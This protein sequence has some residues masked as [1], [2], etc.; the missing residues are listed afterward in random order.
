MQPYID[1]PAVKAYCQDQIAPAYAEA[2]K[3][4]DADYP[5]WPA[6][7][8]YDHG[9]GKLSWAASC[10]KHLAECRS[11]LG[12]APPIPPSVAD[13]R[14]VRANFCN[15]TDSTGRPIYSAC[16]AAQ[17]PAMQGEWLQREIDAGGTHYL[18]CVYSGYHDLYGERVHF[19]RAK[20]WP[21]F[22]DALQRI[23]DAGLTPIV[24]LDPGD[25]CPGPQHFRDM[26]AAMP[27]SLYPRCVWVPAFEPV[28]GAWTSKQFNEVAHAI[29]AAL[30]PDPLLGYHLSPGRAAFSSNPVAADDPWQGAEMG[31]WHT[32][33]GVHADLFLYQSP[34]PP[35]GVYDTSADGWCSRAIEVRDRFLGGHPP[36]PDWFARPRQRGRPTLVWM[37]A[38]AFS[39][40]RGQSS[41]AWASEVARY[42][43]TLGYQ[44]FGNGLP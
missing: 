42:A 22:L 27:A 25:A 11:A 40:I 2:Q 21:E 26:I 20:R 41:S 31:C 6:R 44:G 9:V 8:V 35:E 29:R 5:V 18:I 19:W 33:S 23:L 32:S 43:Q 3:P 30:G 36:A 13:P 7:A 12:L 38:T 4:L 24:M 34:V 39:F 17:T 16:L 10:A 15:L 37:E 1:D 14:L 28:A